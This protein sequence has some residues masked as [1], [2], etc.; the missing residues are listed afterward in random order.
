ML[1]A[2][3]TVLRVQTFVIP[4]PR[5]RCRTDSIVEF[6][7]TYRAGRGEIPERFGGSD[8][9]SFLIWLEGTAP[10]IWI[11]ETP[12]ILAFPFILYLHTL[13]LALIAGLSSGVALAI[14][15][16]PGSARLSPLFRLFPLMWIGLGINVLSGIAL[17]MAY[18][19][20]ALTNPVFY[21]KLVAVAGAVGILQWLQGR[22]GV[23]E[24]ADAISGEFQSSSDP[25]LRAAAW[26]ML[27]LWLIA[28]LTGRLLAYTHSILLASV[29]I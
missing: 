27:S 20:K 2:V 17:L 26:A 7:V 3:N 13:G 1:I 21:I 22:F 14:I 28:T 23:T 4:T 9:L 24:R 10:S 16:F 19:A 8:S 18:P 6:A 15:G 25:R 12:S 5:N 11:R 29:G